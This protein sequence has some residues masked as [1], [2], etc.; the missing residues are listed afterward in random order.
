MSDNEYD[1]IFAECKTVAQLEV[2]SDEEYNKA[3]DFCVNDPELLERVNE[4]I[5]EA[6]SKR[7]RELEQKLWE[8]DRDGF[9]KLL[10]IC[11]TTN[12]L[13]VFFWELRTKMIQV[14]QC[15][16]WTINRALTILEETAMER[17]TQLQSKPTV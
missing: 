17:E 2:R 16:A 6:Y 5:T 8:H 15:D 1:A 7:R 11:R 10:S 13:N 14:S 3:R 12:E 9:R 4:N